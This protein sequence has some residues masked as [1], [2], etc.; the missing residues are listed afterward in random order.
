MES[1][2]GY[3]M[4]SVGIPLLAQSSSP[5]LLFT[6]HPSQISRK[7]EVIILMNVWHITLKR[8]NWA[9]MLERETELIKQIIIESTINGREAIKLSDVI[10]TSLPRGVKTFMTAEVVKL[11]ETDF[12]QSQR[13]SQ[14]TQGIGSTIAVERSLLHAL[15]MEYVLHRDEYLKLVEDTVHFLENYL[16]RPQWTLCQLMFEKEKSVSFDSLAKK[17]E[18]V[19]DYSYLRM[20]IERHARRNNVKEIREEQFRSLLAKIDEEVVKQHSPRELALLTKPIFDFLLFG[21]AS[22]TR[23]VPLGAIL[24]F[25]EDKKMVGVKDYI[26]RICQVRSRTQISMT[27]LIGIL[28][29]LFR[30]ET[31]VKDDVQES[32]QEI[33]KPVERTVESEPKPAISETPVTAA[34]GALHTVGDNGREKTPVKENAEPSA[35]ASAVESLTDQTPRT[36]EQPKVKVTELDTMELERDV[37]AIEIPAPRIVNAD[38]L[39]AYAK[40]REALRHAAFLTF[41]ERPIQDELGEE[42]PDIQEMLTKEQR[43]QFINSIFKKDENYFFIFLTSLNNART[44]RDAQPFL[45]DLFEMNS[46]NI[47]SR[48]VVEFTDAMQARYHPELRNAE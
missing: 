48:D 28:E 45:R 15:A 31:A 34:A 27:E 5:L 25:F 36:E 16:C 14:I 39:V 29:D 32:E 33:L 8:G 26:E 1:V 18:C 24:L 3:S 46:L 20:V 13:L 10:A 21:D 7:F 47:R 43:E 30:V 23:P 37:S 19:V 41:P 22:M 40:E 38:E 12:K 42:L 35:A 9:A 44:W 17:F 4:E 6:L 11:L 2:V